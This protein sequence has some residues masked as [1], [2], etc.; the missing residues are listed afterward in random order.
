MRRKTQNLFLQS[1]FTLALIIPTFFTAQS[2]EKNADP[3]TLFADIEMAVSPEGGGTTHPG[4]GITT[5]IIGIPLSITASPS[6]G[7]KFSSWAVDGVVKVW[8]TSLNETTAYTYGNGKITAIFEKTAPQANLTM[9][10]SPADSGSTDPEVGTYS[11]PIGQATSITAMAADGY[12]FVSWTIVGNATVEDEESE[13]TTTTLTGDAT[14]T[15]NFAAIPVSVTLT[16]DVSPVASGS[17]VP[18]AGD[19][20]VNTGDPIAITATP[21]SGYLFHFWNVEKGAAV[22]GDPSSPETTVILSGDATVTA[23]FIMVVT[24]ATLAMAV[25]P[26]ASGTT[27]PVAGDHLEPIGIPIPITATPAADYYFVS[28]TVSGMAKIENPFD[29]TTTATLLDNAAVT[30]N[31]AKVVINA[32]LTMASTSG[33]NID[34]LAG[35]H[36]VPIGVPISI[37]ATADTDY[38]FSGWSVR[39]QAVVKDTKLAETTVVLKGDATVTANFE[40]VVKTA[41]LTMNAKPKGYGYTSPGKGKHTVPIGE[42]I[43]IQAVPAEEYFFSGWK[44]SGNADIEDISAIKTKI[45]LIGNATVTANFAKVVTTATLTMAVAAA[46]SGSTNPGVGE[47]TVAVGESTQ[48]EA[49]PAT[50]YFFSGWTSAGS[51]EIKDPF[52]EKTSV[53]LSGNATVTANFEKVVR[54]VTLVMEISPKGSGTTN[55]GEGEHTVAVGD[56][57]EIEAI[58]GDGYFFSRWSS[59]GEVDIKDVFSEKTT[60]TLSSNAIVE[61][62]FSKVVTTATLTMTASP[63]DSGSTDPGLGEHTVTVGDTIDIEAVPG[64]GYYFLKWSGTE[65]ATIENHL[66]QKTTA[67]LSADATITANFAKVVKIATLTM[68]VSPSDSGS[69]NPGTGDHAVAVGDTIEIQAIPADNYFFSG[70]TSAGAADIEDPS[71]DKTS[72]VLSGNAAVTANFKQIVETATLT[73]AAS[74]EDTGTTDPGT[75]PHMVAVGDSI[76]IQAFPADGYF[77][78]KW[79]IIGG[80][81]IDDLTADKTKAILSSDAVITANFAKVVTTATLTMEVS[82]D[83]SGTTNPTIGTHTVA[84]GD[85]IEIQAFPADGYFFYRWNSTG[86]A[87][88]RD[89]SSEKSAVILSGDATVTA[90]FEKIVR[91]ATLTMSTSPNDG[92]STDPGIGEHTV[93]I[94]ESTE[95]EALPADGYFFDKWTCSGDAEIDDPS[96]EKS[97][98]VL[99]SEATVTANFAKIVTTAT[100]TMAVS[101]EDSGTTN[102]NPGAHTVAVGEGIEIQAIPSDGYFFDE[103]TVS[104]KVEIEDT[105][106]A[107]TRV[108]LSGDGTV[109]ANFTKIVNIAT[110]TMA[111]SAEG[112]GSTNPGIGELLVP[113]GKAVEIEAIPDKDYFFV[114]WVTTGQGTVTE[115]LD[116]KT[117]VVLSGD[118]T[119]TANF[120]SWI[121][122]A[123]LAMVITPEDSG[124][125]NPSVGVHL[126]P[127]GKNCQIEAAFAEGYSFNNWSI[128][129]K[130][131]INKSSSTKTFVDLSGDAA[132]TAHFVKTGS[133]CNLAMA[134]LPEGWGSTNPGVGTHAV[135]AGEGIDIE[136][137]PAD[138]YLFYCWLASYSVQIKNSYSPQTTV[139]LSADGMVTA[140]FINETS[141]VTLTMAVSPED[142]GETSPIIGTHTA[143]SLSPVQIEA[144]PATGQFF[145][146]WVPSKNA[147]VMDPFSPSSSAILYGDATV[148]ALFTYYPVDFVS[149]GSMLSYS[150]SE[151]NPQFHDFTKRPSIWGVYTDPVSGKAG[152]KASV[153]NL[154]KINK[155]SYP[156]TIS[157]EWKKKILLYKRFLYWQ[158][159]Y[160]VSGKLI[161]NPISNLFMDWMMIRS[162][163]FGKDPLYIQDRITA[164]ACPS[165][166]GINGVYA[167]EGDKFKITGMFFGAKAPKIYVECKIVSSGGKETYRYFNCKLVKDETY[168]FKNASGKANS[169][170]M[171]ILVDDNPESALG[172]P[173]GG[174]VVTALYPKL[175]DAVP[176]GYLM[177]NNAPGISILAFP[178]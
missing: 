105:T 23:H 98:V 125:T 97:S 145:A 149:T 72:V 31:F 137:E 6:E 10:I 8:D 52:S 30:A 107:A 22:I 71:S 96:S 104:G 122:T 19:H 79:S 91:T 134:V 165:I 78:D 21:A 111:V 167:A 161:L 143:F 154:T 45:N 57:V 124:T 109:T 28:W 118:A 127:V 95:I 17:T 37:T 117:T 9:A 34:P 64:D 46:D 86:G 141:E 168:I 155:K 32:T 177:L 93:A 138:G 70:W 147:V 69:T 152:K 151:V 58:T 112:G 166:S 66:C 113:V 59:V 115:I 160:S 174:S 25:S 41:T 176:T 159:G 136:A 120:A 148:T 77:F 36:A 38:F 162:P 163:Q 119:V 61:A 1:I 50:D 49:V 76:E 14:V 131:S 129:G 88:I 130:G 4:A 40:S 114:G 157:T 56:R 171:K 139:R 27:D 103:W 62:Q 99:T 5:W 33:G 60:A 51:A 178:K 90:K 123:E 133:T 80:A 44:V 15:A 48:I 16:M 18:I 39:G 87:Q 116:E 7:Y 126:L 82:P 142:G 24:P 132:I 92:G 12:Y 110:L 53:V 158:R 175:G 55:P 35:D 65:A 128:M 81:D 101:P 83:L 67:T 94:G 84:A 144:Y 63:E 153:R 75:G 3:Q 85:S 29:P 73:M 89:T 106:L 146:C 54:T 150:I 47:H 135:A 42:W 13:E 11:V 43:E 170:C 100:L 140:I 108:K 20:A 172:L 121:G 156:T 68:V 169:S 74:P 102:P 26:D 2:A 164:L 173:V